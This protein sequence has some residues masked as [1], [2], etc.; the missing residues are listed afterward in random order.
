MFS[1]SM[2][3][4]LEVSGPSCQI[5]FACQDGHV[6]YLWVIGWVSKCSLKYL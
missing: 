3:V 6:H 2:L 1:D 5:N 4:I